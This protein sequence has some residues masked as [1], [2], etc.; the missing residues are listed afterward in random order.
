VV[1]A[2]AV[3]TLMWSALGLGERGNGSGEMGAAAVVCHNGMKA[4]VSEGK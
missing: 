3:G 4:A 2:A 1:R